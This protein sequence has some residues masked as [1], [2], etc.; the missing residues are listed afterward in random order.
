MPSGTPFAWNKEAVAKR[1]YKN[2]ALAML[3]ATG[4]AEYRAD[5]LLRFRAANN[6]TDSTAAIAAVI[7]TDCEERGTMLAEF[8]E[9]W[10]DEPL[11]VL[12]WLS[13]Q[14]RLSRLTGLV[15]RHT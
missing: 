13:M 4:E 3:C 15:V 10:K 6:M 5:A 8:Y 7:H 1:A 9:R 2:K 11:V 12:K 14:A